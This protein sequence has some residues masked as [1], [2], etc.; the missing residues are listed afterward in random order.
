MP[1]AVILV[2]AIALG[3]IGV[4]VGQTPVGRSLFEGARE[5]VT[6]DGGGEAPDETPPGITSVAAFDPAGDGKE[7]DDELDNVLDGDPTTSWRTE[8]YNSRADFQG[9]KEGVGIVLTLDRAARLGTLVATSPSQE[10]AAEVYVA[11]QAGD[12][13]D[14]WGEP[15][16]EVGGIAGDGRFDLGGAQGR[17]VL[18]WL[19][20]IGDGQYTEISQVALEP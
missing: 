1:T 11:N 7:R 3:V 17:E 4:L 16:A 14:D 19:T 20:D 13:L 6:S 8:R 10:W 12:S 18:L 9:L 5:A 15:V 2:V